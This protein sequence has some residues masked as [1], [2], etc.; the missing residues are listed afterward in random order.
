MNS[1]YQILLDKMISYFI[2]D[3]HEKAYQELKRRADECDKDALTILAEFYLWGIYV[4]QDIDYAIELLEQAVLV[5]SGDACF[6]LCKLY[7]KISDTE[8][9]IYPDNDKAINYAT[10]GVQLGNV[11]CMAIMSDLLYFGGPNR[12]KIQ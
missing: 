4:S 3:E 6:E 12:S 11:G 8:I 5:G 2:D 10:Q 9:T 1:S 7:L